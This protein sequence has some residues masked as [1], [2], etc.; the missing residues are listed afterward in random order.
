[1]ETKSSIV[2]PKDMISMNCCKCLE[3]TV[4]SFR[5]LTGCCLKRRKQFAVPDDSFVHF[6]IPLTLEHERELLQ[7][8]GF[9]IE[10]VLDDP[11][12]ATSIAAGKGD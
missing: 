12:G 7:N 3:V 8:A 6:D 11:D 4:L 1:M 10:K 9:V 2:P 5:L